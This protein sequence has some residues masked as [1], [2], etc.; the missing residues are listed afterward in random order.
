[1][2]ERGAHRGAHGLGK[3]RPRSEG[4]AGRREGERATT[5]GLDCVACA[6]VCAERSMGIDE[7]NTVRESQL[8]GLLYF[9]G[10]AFFLYNRSLAIYN[11]SLIVLPIG[12]SAIAQCPYVRLCERWFDRAM[13][14]GKIFNCWPYYVFNGA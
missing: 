9:P 5:Q 12:V 11:I 4:Q 3:H 14:H 7:K 13:M 6:S 2:Y 8:I 10:V 1:M